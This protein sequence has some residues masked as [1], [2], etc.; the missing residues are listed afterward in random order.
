MVRTYWMYNV[1]AGVLVCVVDGIIDYNFM[2]I[3]MSFG[4]TPVNVLEAVKTHILGLY[5]CCHL[6][7]RKE[8]RW[9][10]PLGNI[11][12]SCRDFWR[13]MLHGWGA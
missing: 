10:A 3:Q 7:K 6:A 9:P 1:L 11:S 13:I 5:F 2:E 8:V 12:E 4:Q